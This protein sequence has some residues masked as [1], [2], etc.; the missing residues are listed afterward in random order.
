M[1]DLSALSRRVRSLEVRWRFTV[2][3]AGVLVALVV[4]GASRKSPD[5]LKARGL[6]IT[7]NDG[8]PRVV[9]GAP[10]ANASADPKL[11]QAVGLAVLDALGRMNVAVGTDAPLVY[12]NGTLGQRLY[13]THTGLTI[14]DPR[15]GGERGGM[16]VHA[17]GH[18]VVCLDYEKDREAV[19]MSVASQDAFADVQLMDPSVAG[20]DR[21]GMFLNEDGVGIVKAG[22]GG[23][24]ANALVLETGVGPTARLVALDNE[25][26]ESA[27][28]LWKPSPSGTGT[29]QRPN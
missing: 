5:V 9:L 20:M 1:D 21:V 13:G 27:E 2:A 14:Y 26:R 10:M 17:D 15:S 8:K 16:G 7:D 4:L 12:S 22:G 11:A 29:E 23:K 24:N 19:C 25:G 3:L 6:I 28:A 18:A